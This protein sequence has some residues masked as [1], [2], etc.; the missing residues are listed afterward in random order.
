MCIAAGCG[1]VGFA[2]LDETPAPTSLRYVENPAL[3]YEH[4]AIEPNVPISEGG[5]ITSFSIEPALPAGLLL[6][7]VTGVISGT[8]DLHVP[9]TA[10]RVTGRNA[11]GEV[12]TSLA[13]TVLNDAAFFVAKTGDDANPGTFERPFLT[14]AKGV[15]VLTPG[16]SLY[17]MT[18][19]YDE[20]LDDTIP[21][22]TSWDEP[23]HVAAFPGDEATIQPTS[24]TQV[25]HIRGPQRKYIAID[26]LILDGTGVSG[27]V[28][29]IA[30]TPD[31]P[32]SGPSNIWINGAEIRNSAAGSGIVLDRYVTNCRLTRLWIHHIN[33]FGII[34]VQGSVY[35]LIEHS[36]IHDIAGSGIRFWLSPATGNIVRANEIHDIGTHAIRFSSSTID[37][38]VHGNRIWNASLTDAG[39]A[40]ISMAGPSD[41]FNNVIF[42]GGG[43][44]IRSE[45][46]THKFYNNTI[47]GNAGAAIRVFPSL[48][49]EVRNNIM[50][51]NAALF[52]YSG[53]DAASSGVVESDNLTSSE[54]AFV[55]P[56]DGD[57]RLAAGSPGVD[58]GATLLEVTEDADGV[59]R[60]RGLAYDIGA[61]ER[62]P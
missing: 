52:S 46:E 15:S 14:I 49:I 55:A 58:E 48:G 10:F 43:Y 12:S 32:G 3:Y 47:Y 42:A 56:G 19:V 28:V 59:L 7:P 44:G 6:D 60:P 24:G 26:G 8:P 45:S 4:T 50:R 41:V 18:G 36:R 40:A 16:A 29:Q 31:V 30:G 13:I 11:G 54:P 57:F 53:T 23:V 5:A 1:R 9:T 20:T 35:T 22:G 39:T 61:Y 37:N 25:I 27:S 2:E 62:E 33:Q 51:A 34:A 38:A 17:V 21:A